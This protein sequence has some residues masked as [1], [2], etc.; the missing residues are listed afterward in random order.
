MSAHLEV[1]LAVVCCDGFL[2]VNVGV[3]HIKVSGIV[4][5]AVI[6]TVS[7]LNR[8]SFILFLEPSL[9]ACNGSEEIGRPVEVRIVVTVLATSV[10]IIIEG[11]RG[12][13][14]LLKRESSEKFLASHQNFAEIYDEVSG[15]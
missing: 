14:D 3:E 1:H 15:E 11:V 5:V 12:C 2:S 10:F 4:P 13:G 6:L 7:D 8:C 9:V